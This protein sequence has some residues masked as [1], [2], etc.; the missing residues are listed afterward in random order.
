MFNISE[1]IQTVKQLID[2]RIKMVEDEISDR[3]SRILTR[4][5]LLILLGMIS[6]MIVLFLSLA[7]AFYISEKTYSSSQ[8]FL[9]VGVLYLLLFLGL[10]LVKDSASVGRSFKAFLKSFVFE[11]YK[12]NEE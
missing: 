1:I 4:I 9:Y 3:L 10:V 8:G 11:K 6:L 2:V 7:L 5:F 12:E